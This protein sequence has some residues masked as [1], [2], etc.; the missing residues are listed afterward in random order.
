MKLILQ[1]AIVFFICLMG[2]FISVILPFPF[3]SSVISMI[4]MFA[5]LM[6]K[7]LKPEHIKDKTDFLLKNMAF[8]FIPSGVGIIEHF[9]Q[10]EGIIVPFLFICILTTVITFA[11]TA[12]TIKGVIALQNKISG[13]KRHD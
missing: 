8:F 1:I 4:L 12:Y 10:I 7:V 6:F 3:P 5:L 2:E 9:S 13:G 11:A